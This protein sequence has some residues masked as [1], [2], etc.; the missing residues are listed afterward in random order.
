MAAKG[1]KIKGMVKK[2]LGA[3]KQYSKAE[4]RREL[5]RA[6]RI[7]QQD[8]KRTL[9]AHVRK[10]VSEHKVGEI[11]KELGRFN[12]VVS[13]KI[14]MMP[15]YSALKK[16]ASGKSAAKKTKKKKAAERSTTKRKPAKRK[17]ARK[18]KR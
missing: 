16:K 2:K 15:Y 13:W 17:A 12:T 3:L 11:K 9:E 8:M 4:L 18:K 6:K 5:S 14:E 10:I 1:G 7:V